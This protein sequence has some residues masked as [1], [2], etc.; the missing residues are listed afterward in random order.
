MPVTLADQARTLMHLQYPVIGLPRLSPAGGTLGVGTSGYRWFQ[1]FGF[2]LYRMQNMQPVEEAMLVGKAVAGVA[3]VGSPNPGDSCSITL[4]GGNI[5]SSQTITA[6]VGAG[7][8]GIDPR[9]I[10]CA[11]LANAAAANTV[12]QGA[13]IFAAAPYG[14]G[15]A[16]QAVVPLPEL[17]FS[18]PVPFTIVATGTGG[19]VPQLTAT[20]ILMPPATS[21]DGIATLNGYLPILD[22]LQNALGTPSQNLDTSSAGPWKARGSEIAQRNALYWR[23]VQML[24]EFLGIPINPRRINTANRVSFSRYL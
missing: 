18:S 13:G 22:G 2:L 11:A 8:T 9:L 21:L 10:L 4:S 3:F 24:S 5:A 15:P 19:A 12:L 16:A 7:Q 14:T 20:G 23:W 1:A 17:A 6:T